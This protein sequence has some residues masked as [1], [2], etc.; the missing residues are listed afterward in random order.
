VIPLEGTVSH[1]ELRDAHNKFQ[2]KVM[3]I[4]YNLDPEG[5][6]RSI[7]APFDEYHDLTA[8]LAP[9]LSRARNSSEAAEEIRR[10]VPTAEPALIEALLVA[11]Q[12]LK[13][14]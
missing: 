13:K 1:S 11:Q 7:D 10:L 12:E 9:R 14:D 8:L 3:R 5:I 6:G 4:L 2:E